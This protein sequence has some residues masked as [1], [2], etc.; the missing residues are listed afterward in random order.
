MPDPNFEAKAKGLYLHP[1]DNTAVF[2]VDE[3]TATQALDR[4]QPALPLRPGRPERQ[5]VE[6]VRHGTVSL[7]ATL[8]VHSERVVGRCAP[9][10]TSQEFMQFLGE[11]VVAIRRKTIHVILDNLV[12]HK[13]SAVQAWAQQHL[14]VTCYFTP[15]YASQPEKNEFRCHFLR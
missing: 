13:A 2:C 8:E 12:V 14:N 15:A 10:H 3:K 9:R 6:Y 7:F 11:A 1:P 5:A 4:I